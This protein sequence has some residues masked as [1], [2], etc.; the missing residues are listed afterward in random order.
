[1]SY[2]IGRRDVVTVLIVIFQSHMC[3]GVFAWHLLD[4][5]I[6]IWIQSRSRQPVPE[7]EREYQRS[8]LHS[9]PEPA[10]NVDGPASQ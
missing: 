7:V 4:D 2:F 9:I 8:D 1:M 5:D 6:V 3:A 10:L